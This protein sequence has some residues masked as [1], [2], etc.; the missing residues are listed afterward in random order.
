MLELR[1][2]NVDKS[3]CARILRGIQVAPVE[4]QE[5]AQRA[6]RTQAQA[7]LEQEL[8]KRA[9]RMRVCLGKGNADGFCEAM[10]NGLDDGAR[11]AAAPETTKL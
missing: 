4:H 1:M 10:C 6:W 2:G 3:F 7:S 8:E 9:T 11:G 5:M